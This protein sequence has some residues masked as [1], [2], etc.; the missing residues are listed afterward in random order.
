MANNNQWQ[1]YLRP[2]A[3]TKDN[4]KDCIAHVH[5]NGATL[6]NEDVAERI[7]GERSEYRKDTILNILKLRDNTVKSFI[8]ECSS[9]RDGLVQITPR[10]SGVWEN[11]ASNFDP[12]VHKRTVDLVPTAD[13]RNMLDGITVK[14]MG[15]SSASAKITAITDSATGLKDGT[16]TIGDDI[17]IDGEKIKITDEADQSQ[18]IFIVDSTGTEH[19][20]TRRLTVNKPSHIIARVPSTVTAGAVTVKIRTNYSGSKNPLSAIREITYGYECTAI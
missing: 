19:R 16:I 8:Q 18:G 20:V 7:I 5:L 2:N 14:V 4:D 1:V 11:E 13:L 10:I 15:T 3:L 12:A 9:F 17:I 6:T